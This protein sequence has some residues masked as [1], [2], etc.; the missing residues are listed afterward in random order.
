MA[1]TTEQIKVLRDQTGI[2]I[3]LCR[4]A[5]E[6]AEGDMEKANVILK[7]RGAEAAQKKADRT[8]GAGTVATYLHHG[9][10]VGTMVELSS[11]TDFVSGNEAFR[12]L[13][14]DIA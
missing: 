10:T 9:G 11:E 6:E 3:M 7:R 5:L 4:K 12:A 2:S 1:I 8:L 13:A 14:Y